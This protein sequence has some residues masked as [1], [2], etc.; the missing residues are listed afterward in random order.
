MT[1]ER[2]GRGKGGRSGSGGADKKPRG[3]RGSPRRRRPGQPGEAP[4]APPGSERIEPNRDFYTDVLQEHL[5]AEFSGLGAYGDPL[6]PEE[7]SDEDI[8]AEL[9]RSRSTE[10]PEEAGADEP[11]LPRGAR[12]DE[13]LSEDRWLDE[14]GIEDEAEDDG[15][16]EARAVLDE[17]ADEEWTIAP[18]GIE[19][20]A[21]G[22]QEPEVEFFPGPEPVE[23]E[24]A[25]GEAAELGPMASQPIGGE[26]GE[27][28]ERPAGRRRGRGR[29]GRGRRRGEPAANGA[30]EAATQAIEGILSSSGAEAAVEDRPQQ[31]EESEAWSGARIAWLWERISGDPAFPLE[32]L[33]RAEIPADASAQY[34]YATGRVKDGVSAALVASPDVDGPHLVHGLRFFSE[35]QARGSDIRQLVLCAPYFTDEVRKAAY[36]V[37]PK[38]VRLRLV[39]HPHQGGADLG[40]RSVETLRTES[41]EVSRSFE[42]VAAEISSPKLRRLTSR[43]KVAAEGALVERGGE[44]A[45]CRGG[46][47]YFRMR[48]MDLLVARAREGGLQIELLHPR[49]RSLKLTEQNFDQALQKVREVFEAARRQP[50]LA[51]RESNFRRAVCQAL[52]EKGSAFTPLD[53]DVAVGSNRTRIDILALR[54]G[55]TPVAIQARTRLTLEDLY[56]GLVA[57]CAL[58]EQAGL[59]KP[60]LGRAGAALDAS[61]DPEL[62][63]A[64]LRTPDTLPPIARLFV[65]RVSFLRVRPER[66]WWETPIQIESLTE[67]VLPEGGA[68]RAEIAAQV[69]APPAAARER[70]VRPALRL[71]MKN[72]A[73]IVS[74]YDRDGIVANIVLARAVHTVAAQRFMNSEDLLTLFFTPEMQEG[75]PEVYDLYITDLRFRPTTRLAPDVRESF[76][77]RLK[78]HPGSVYWFDHVYWQDVDRRDMESAIGRSNLVIAPKERTAAQVVRNA[79]RIRDPFSDKLVD[80]L[81]GKLPPAE[82][83]G[84]GKNW[85]SVIDYLRNDL[86]RI[87]SAVQP[88]REGRPEDVS[89]DLLEEGIRKEGEAERYVSERDF[90]VVIFGSYKMVVVDLP[91][92]KT[93]NYTS[94]TQ[95]VRD[96]YRAQLSITT[97]GDDETILIA[98]SFSSRKGM[99]MSLIKEHLT[100]KFDWLKPVQGHENVIT[101]RV[102]DLPSKRE[103]LDMI[104][105]EIV[106]NRSLFA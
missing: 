36:L 106:R 73:V 2:R 79:L 37:D 7:A 1:Q 52:E 81:Y 90:R 50:G 59:L 70:Q 95:K 74:H 103:R 83:N 84:W 29:R 49:G 62:V 47:I 9:G 78:S 18:A 48:G 42:E 3:R 100:K 65:P 5:E 21:E 4:S 54:S 33:E 92:K 20:G 17:E 67:G 19:S 104:I 61:R 51:Q 93:F 58:R 76:I 26:A 12:T 35:L 71:E 68:A 43:F 10:L 38:R 94:V 57:F 85:L 56:R 11:E 75:L 6:D 46:K 30:A 34:I 97:F 63:F 14:P 25:R 82:F 89:T 45:I 105:N 23:S 91:D 99:S 55:G 88:L 13:S 8:A 72:P 80:L 77:D 69:A 102:A 28:R 66:R 87:E 44:E 86:G 32:Q 16:R 15:A 24:A 27:A 96:R 40:Y 22:V 101:L 39:K 41:R 64:S 31:P 53:E 60:A 98:N